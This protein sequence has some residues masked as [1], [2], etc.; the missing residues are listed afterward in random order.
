MLVQELGRV[1]TGPCDHRSALLF[2]WVVRDSSKNHEVTAP[3]STPGPAT[4]SYTT[5]L[6]ATSCPIRREFVD[7]FDT[8]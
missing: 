1:D 7:G 8:P 6:D 3:T 5:L 2:E 4:S